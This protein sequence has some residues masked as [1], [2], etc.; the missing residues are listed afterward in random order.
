MA[1]LRLGVR[2]L[3]CRVVGHVPDRWSHWTRIGYSTWE[4]VRMCQRCGEEIERQNAVADREGVRV[5][6]GRLTRL[7]TID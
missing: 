2:R 3:Y 6:A 5:I 1:G 4:R 7:D